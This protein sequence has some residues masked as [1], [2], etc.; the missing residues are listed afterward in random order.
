MS[1]N[2]ATY[3][4]MSS[5]RCRLTSAAEQAHEP[6]GPAGHAPCWSPARAGLARARARRAPARSAGYARRYTAMNWTPVKSNM[7]LPLIAFCVILVFFGAAKGDSSEPVHVPPVVCHMTVD[8]DRSTADVTITWSGGTPPFTLVRGNTDHFSK[9][10]RLEVLSSRLHSRR[11][12][13]RGAFVPGKRFYYQ[14]Y[15]HNSQPEVFEFTP[16]GGLPGAVITVRGV[17]F[18]PDCSKM[19]VLMAGTKAEEKLDC[20]FTSFK[21]KVPKNAVTGSLIVA[22]PAGATVPGT[23]QGDYCNGVRRQPTS[24]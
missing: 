4:A 5:N 18:A 2:F 19:T 10:T 23:D 14:V 13:D 17:A 6:D 8:A 15:D 21:F 12:V 11:F 24:W 7:S 20:T 22:T 1:L 9:A 3:V 16:D